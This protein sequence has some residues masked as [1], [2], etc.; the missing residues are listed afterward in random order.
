MSAPLISTPD[1]AWPGSDP[2]TAEPVPSPFG[3]LLWWSYWG[4][5]P[6]VLWGCDV[7]CLAENADFVQL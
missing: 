6:R 3:L 1:R 5:V 7:M 4:N 2:G